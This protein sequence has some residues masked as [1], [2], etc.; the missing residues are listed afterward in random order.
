ME[1]AGR[2]MRVIRRGSLGVLALIALAA[3]DDRPGG[4]AAIVYP[5]RTDRTKFVVTPRF[6]SSSYCLEAAKET[7]TRTQVSGGGAYECGY[8]C[9]LDGDPHRMNICEKY[10]RDS[11]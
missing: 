3:C 9:E 11:D 10:R 6:T 1:S 8:N 5:D 4:W 7:M 2:Q